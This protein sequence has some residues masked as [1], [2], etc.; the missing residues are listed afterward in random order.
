MFRDSWSVGDCTH[1][2]LSLLG[3]LI[4]SAFIASC[5][6]RSNDSCLA[7]ESLCAAID[8]MMECCLVNF[9]LVVLRYV[10]INYL[11]DKLMNSPIYPSPCFNIVK[12]GYNHR[13]LFIKTQRKLLNLTLSVSNNLLLIMMNLSSGNSLNNEISSNFCLRFANILLTEQKLTIQ[14]GH[15]NCIKVDNMDV[16]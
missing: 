8:Q 11:L 7:I 4:Q 2:K 9:T 10:I 14:V 5:F 16:L 12:A 1:L 15:V 6:V 3:E 13:K